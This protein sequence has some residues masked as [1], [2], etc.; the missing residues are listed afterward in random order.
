LEAQ[1]LSGY[2]P[3]TTARIAFFSRG[4][5]LSQYQHVKL[6]N[7]HFHVKKKRK[8]QKKKTGENK[9]NTLDKIK[10]GF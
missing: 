2:T 1:A 4:H 7:V 9:E 6:Q 10:G 3:P 8:K 5:R